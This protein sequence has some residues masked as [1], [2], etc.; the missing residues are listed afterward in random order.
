MV[1]GEMMSNANIDKSRRVPLVEFLRTVKP[2]EA[3]AII[4]MLAQGGVAG[5]KN[6]NLLLPQLEQVV[7]NLDVLFFCQ[8]EL[9]DPK[10]RRLIEVGMELEDV[11]EL[12][13]DQGELLRSCSRVEKM[14]WDIDL[15]Q[16]AQRLKKKRSLTSEK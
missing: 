14:I 1:S 5:I 9:K 16:E 12:V 10:L 11:A 13:K 6:G 7:F 4:V 3:R 8:R 2:E 15:H